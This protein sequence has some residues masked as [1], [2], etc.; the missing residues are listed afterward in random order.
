[1]IVQWRDCEYGAPEINPK[2]PYG[3]SSVELD[4]CE[5]LGW[6]YDSENEDLID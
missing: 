6:K 2:R 4:I 1:M 5:I 3:N